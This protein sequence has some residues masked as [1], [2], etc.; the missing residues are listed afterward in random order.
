[1]LNNNKGARHMFRIALCGI[2][3]SGGAMLFENLGLLDNYQAWLVSG[4][5]A[6][7]LLFCIPEQG[8]ARDPKELI[9]C[10]AG[11]IGFYAILLKLRP[12]LAESVGGVL[13]AVVS[14]LLALVLAGVIL[15]LSGVRWLTSRTD[16]AP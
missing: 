16:P 2:V 12:W 6:A 3:W 4:V 14:I 8:K 10:L 7:V 5:I 1:M 9:S 11:V 13:A 15:R